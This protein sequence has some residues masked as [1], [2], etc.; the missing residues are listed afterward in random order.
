[1]RSIVAAN[2]KMYKTRAEALATTR[3]LGEIFARTPD[4]IESVIFAPF[5]VL[6]A[7]FTGLKTIPGFFLGGEDVYPAKEGAFTGEISPAMLLDCGC[8][9]VL[10][11]HSERR[12]IL[13][14]SPEFVGQKTSFALENGLSV[15]LC[16]GE[17]LEERENGQLEAVLRSQLGKGLAGIADD[18]LNRIA[19]AYEPV[20]AIGT[21]KVAS[22]D[23]IF[24]AHGIVRKL[25]AE[26]VPEDAA[27]GM[28]ILYGG[29]VKPNNA[30]AI[31]ALDNVN[32][33]LVGGASLQAESFAAIIRAAQKN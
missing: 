19:I 1:M 26:F 17:T 32:G 24:A 20:W 21:G 14:E 3:Q 8:T 18:A 29:S 23:D 6:D 11:G 30:Q 10:T 27:A 28:P 15:M 4:G 7:A 12:H 22:T 9:W 16:I 31:M 33:L 13:G 2:W 25:L 5:T